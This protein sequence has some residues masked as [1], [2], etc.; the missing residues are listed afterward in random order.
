MNRAVADHQ[1]LVTTRPLR[2]TLMSSN[3]VTRGH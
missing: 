2:E 3:D 1:L